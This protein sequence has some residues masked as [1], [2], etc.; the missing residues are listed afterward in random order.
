MTGFREVCKFCG[1][2]ESCGIDQIG[3]I[4]ENSVPVPWWC[5]RNPENHCIRKNQLHCFFSQFPAWTV[6]CVPHAG[7]DNRPFRSPAVQT[8]RP[9]CILTIS[10]AASSAF[11]SVRSVISDTCGNCSLICEKAY[12]SIFIHQ[13]RNCI[14]A[15]FHCIHSFSS[16]SEFR[17]LTG[18]KK[19]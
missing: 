6:C 2:G 11:R 14:S 10:F 4:R 16:P 15:H 1:T 8:S 12:G 13:F 7:S 17:I 19:L 5:F 18:S 9:Q 3:L